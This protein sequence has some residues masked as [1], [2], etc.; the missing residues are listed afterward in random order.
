MTTTVNVSKEIDKLELLIQF[1]TLERDILKTYQQNP[2]Q[3][4]LMF[5]QDILDYFG[6][7]EQW[8]HKTPDVFA[9]IMATSIIHKKL[10]LSITS[11]GIFCS[12]KIVGKKKK[13]STI[14]EIKEL[15][16]MYADGWKI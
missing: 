14:A 7:K 2:D 11:N 3:F 4:V 9:T 12:L 13:K 15:F 5:S 1:L 10:S 6:I 8:I 16:M